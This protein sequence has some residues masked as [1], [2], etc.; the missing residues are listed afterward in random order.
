MQ[1]LISLHHTLLQHLCVCS[2]DMAGMRGP[3]TRNPSSNM[4][5]PGNMD[6]H[7]QVREFHQEVTRWLCAV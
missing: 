3:R 2:A 7:Q 5:V 1:L 4:C 6:P